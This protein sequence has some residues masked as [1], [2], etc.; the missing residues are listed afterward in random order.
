ME[1]SFNDAEV[2]VV[3]PTKENEGSS[4]SE[5]TIRSCPLATNPE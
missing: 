1:F 5:A 3:C 2:E 4:G